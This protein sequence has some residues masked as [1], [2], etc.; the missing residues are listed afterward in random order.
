MKKKSNAIS[1]NH[2]FKKKLLNGGYLIIIIIF[3]KHYIIYSN[4]LNS[5][6]I[7]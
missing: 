4:F 7:I 2:L 3:Q 1:L 6:E 5:F